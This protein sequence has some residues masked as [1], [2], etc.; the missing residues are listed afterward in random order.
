MK[1]I[2]SKIG[3]KSPQQHLSINAHLINLFRAENFFIPSWMMIWL[4]W[5]YNDKLLLVYE[6]KLVFNSFL[7]AARSKHRIVLVTSMSASVWRETG[8]IKAHKFHRNLLVRWRSLCV[9]WTR[10]FLWNY[11]H[12]SEL[13]ATSN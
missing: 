13:H 6:K 11:A 9:Y 1:L 7:T 2:S 5:K 8:Y 10:L 4:Y 12:S 3:L